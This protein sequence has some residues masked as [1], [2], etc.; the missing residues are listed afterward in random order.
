MMLLILSCSVSMRSC[1]R[2]TRCS[3]IHQLH[4]PLLEH[5]NS[6]MQILHVLRRIAN[7]CRPVTL[8]RIRPKRTL[9]TGNPSIHLHYTWLL[10][11]ISTTMT[12][13]VI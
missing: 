2:R 3:H 6:M 5:V 4:A 10:M 1:R 9:L 13:A 12:S 8:S 11:M 7:N